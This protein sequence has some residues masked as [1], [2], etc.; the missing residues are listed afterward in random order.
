MEQRAIAAGFGAETAKHMGIQAAG[1]E[2]GFQGVAGKLNNPD[3]SHA[4]VVAI[5]HP[6]FTTVVK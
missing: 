2:R 5:F 1:I 3:G 4:D 6:R